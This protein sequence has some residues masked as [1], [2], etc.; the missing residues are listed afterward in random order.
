MPFWKR[1]TS[2]GRKANRIIKL[3]INTGTTLSHSTPIMYHDLKDTGLNVSKADDE[4]LKL[5]R[6][7][8]QLSDVLFQNSTIK[9][10][11]T[12]SD[13]SFFNFSTSKEEEN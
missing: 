5:L 12:S 4:L 10:L 11:Y 3:F 13:K 7:T 2:N 6:E 9:K 1:F 8:Y